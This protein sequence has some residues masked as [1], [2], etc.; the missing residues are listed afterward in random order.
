MEITA[1]KLNHY[2]SSSSL[3]SDIFI[4]NKISLVI[5]I[6]SDRLLLHYYYAFQH[7]TQSDVL[8]IDCDM[9]KVETAGFLDSKRNAR[10]VE[11]YRVLIHQLLPKQISFLRRFWKEFSLNFHLC[12]SVGSKSLLC[13][14]VRMVFQ[15]KVQVKILVLTSHLLVVLFYTIRYDLSASWFGAHLFAIS[16]SLFLSSSVALF[17]PKLIMRQSTAKKK[18]LSFKKASMVLE[19]ERRDGSVGHHHVN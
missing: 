10:T 11:L 2:S 12:Y 9:G 17:D 15:I 7:R 14:R 19:N 13:W 4:L 16:I 18:L 5:R 6:Q 8:S 3:P 1:W